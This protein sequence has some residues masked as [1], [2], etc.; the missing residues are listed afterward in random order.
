MHLNMSSAKWR[1]FCLD[2]NVLMHVFRIGVEI[3][4]KVCAATYEKYFNIF[5]WFDLNKNTLSALLE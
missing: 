3:N 5:I 2:L 1:S 4:I